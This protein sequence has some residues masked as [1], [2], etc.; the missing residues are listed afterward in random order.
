VHTRTADE[1]R[2]AVETAGRRFHEVKADLS[3]IDQDDASAIVHDVEARLGPLDI[4]INNA[5]TIRR[6]DA[7]ETD[8]ADWD[9][10]IGTNLDSVWRLSQAAGKVMLPRASGKIVTI[11][12]L[13]S[14]QGGIRVPAYAA[15]KHAVA[16]LTKALA[17]EWAGRGVNV[18]AVAPGYI[19]TTNTDAL[20][21][22][23][24]RSADILARIPAGRWG[25]PDDIAGAVVFLSSNAANYVHGQILA[26]DGGWL[27]R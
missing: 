4:L 12:S 2:A 15:A 13:L 6:A 20:R 5:G 10:V 7:V 9:Y 19:E 23:P 25:Q 8:D 27:A 3:T 22:D 18:N 1:V 21:A 11:A 24:K 14:F 26:V 16:G 17:N